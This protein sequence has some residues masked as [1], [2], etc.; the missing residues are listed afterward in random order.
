MIDIEIINNNK[1]Y[2]SQY[3]TL[4]KGTTIQEL[5]NNILNLDIKNYKIGVYGK[6]QQLSYTLQDK[7]RV[8]FYEDII[9]DPKIKRE[10]RAKNL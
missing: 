10:K 9:A 8:E 6:I 1:D 5:V 2:K 7:D 4:E 3:L